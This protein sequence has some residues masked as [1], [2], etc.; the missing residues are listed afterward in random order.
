[1]SDEFNE[2]E[3]DRLEAHRHAIREELEHGLRKLS[4]PPHMHAAIR[5]HVIDRQPVGD[6]LTA[7]LSNDLKESVKRADHV[8]LL[9]LI[10][11]VDLLY[12]YCPTDCW[13]SPE[14]VA[15]WLEGRPNEIPPAD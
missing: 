8:N 6:F 9:A 10:T 3:F 15:A 13:G 2:A 5:T 7:V 14:K 1:M 12:N 11:W 4:I